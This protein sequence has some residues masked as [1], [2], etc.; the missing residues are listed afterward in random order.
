L[1]YLIDTN[2]VSEALRAKPSRNVARFLETIPEERFYLSVLT[3]GEIRKGVESLSASAHR[4]RLRAWLEV[5]LLSRFDERILGVD[6]RVS[7]VWGRMLA[8]RKRPAAA[9][10][11]LIAATALAHDLTV[12]TRNLANFDFE[13]LR[14]VNPFTAKVDG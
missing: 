13:G 9:I 6:V 11:S 1:N 8:G 12:L 10:D 2:V 5:D 4:E 7:E 14:V 3:L